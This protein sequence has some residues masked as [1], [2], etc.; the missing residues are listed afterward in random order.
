MAATLAGLSTLRTPTLEVAYLESGPQDGPLVL[1]LHGFPYD[2]HAYAEV[3]PALARAG[4]RVL[5]P[6]LRGHGPT[7]FLH[8]ATP[9]SGQ[10]AALGS[11]ISD[12][13]DALDAGPAILA[14]YDWGGRAACVAAA[15]WPERVKG[16]VTVGGYNILDIVGSVTPGP[17]EQEWRWWY[18]YYFHTARGEAGLRLNRREL[19]RLLWRL[20]SPSWSFDDETFV[21]SAAAFDNPDWVDVVVQSYR[22][23]FGYAAGDPALEPIEQ[24]LARQPPITVPTVVLHG[25]DDGVAPPSG[26]TDLSRFTGRV[27]REVV[28]GAGHNLPQERSEAVIGAVLS[29]R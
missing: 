29:L 25:A 23:R 5:V 18:Q 8:R 1:L 11:D 3:A 27:Y 19:C 9:R 10:Q 4:C 28:A 15:L 7:R 22:H 21:R 20:W 12:L 17:A 24:A 14:G 16:L 13:L 6:Y 2:V 26:S